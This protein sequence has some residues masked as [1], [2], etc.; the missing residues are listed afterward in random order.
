MHFLLTNDDGYDAEGLAALYRAID[1]SH[2]VSIVAPSKEQSRT[3]HAPQ[4]SGPIAVRRI[5]H[6]LFGSTFVVEGRP[7][8]CVRLAFAHLL[9][10]RPDVVVAG[11]NRGANLG[12]AEMMASGTIAAA[13][14]GAFCGARAI[15]VSQMYQYG[16]AVD[17][18]RATSL[19]A[20]LIEQLLSD[21]VP[22]VGL[23]GVNLPALPPGEQPKGVLVAPLS[24]EPIPLDYE[25]NG[26]GPPGLDETRSYEFKGLYGAR[27]VTSGT[28]VE[29]INAGYVV[30]TPMTVNPTD[31]TALTASF[32][33]DL[34]KG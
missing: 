29:A 7:A 3:G 18:S 27:P 4:L 33:L 21:D 34:P 30:V 32:T 10:E 5:A 19:A 13:R 28:D 6:D 11:I 25:N 16:V 14:E 31:Y 15:A 23:W 9:D 20:V 22:Q 1:P 17:W 2:R 24:N 26:S 12:A 8:D